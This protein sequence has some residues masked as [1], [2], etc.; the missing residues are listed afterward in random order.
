M[1]AAAYSAAA[2]PVYSTTRAEL[3][4]RA[5]YNHS[6]ARRPRMRLLLLLA[7]PA[8]TIVLFAF[9]P[10]GTWF[11]PSCPFFSL[12]GWLCPACGTLRALHALLHGQLDRAFRDNAFALTV[13]LATAGRPAWDRLRGW[14]TAPRPSVLPSGRLSGWLLL[15]AV[16]F[17]VARNIPVGPF[18]WLAP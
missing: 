15:A 3:G 6:R 7:L 9:D 12:T 13:G 10:A 8:A 1:A 18:R 2:I 4:T 17:T 5:V 14:A 11:F 16:A